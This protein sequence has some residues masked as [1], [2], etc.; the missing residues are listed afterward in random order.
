MYLLFYLCVRILRFS[1]ILLN[2]VHFLFFVRM[3]NGCDFSSVIGREEQIFIGAN[4]NA[5]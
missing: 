5:G 1:Q 4:D 3:S 2:A